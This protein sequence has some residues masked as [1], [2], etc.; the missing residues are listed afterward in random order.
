MSLDPK[1]ADPSGTQLAVPGAYVFTLT[2]VPYGSSSSSSSAILRS[3]EVTLRP[4]LLKALRCDIAFW[5]PSHLALSSVIWATVV[6]SLDHNARIMRLTFLKPSLILLER[7]TFG[8]A[9]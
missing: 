4:K 5:S 8:C 1:P 9:G 3:S 2:L 6:G 7:S